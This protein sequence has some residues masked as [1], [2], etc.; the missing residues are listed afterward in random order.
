MKTPSAAEKHPPVAAQPAPADAK[1][2]PV[3]APKEAIPQA[4]GSF[5]RQAD[6]SLKP[7]KG[8]R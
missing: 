6:G 4:G 7:E 8:A 3:F 2:D 5:V 1:V